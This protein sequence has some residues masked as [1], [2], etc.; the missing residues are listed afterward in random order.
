MWL[1]IEFH[2]ILMFVLCCY[3][4]PKPYYA[5]A[6][7]QNAITCDLDILLT[8]HSDAIIIVAGDFN[9]L[10]TGF[11]ER[12]FGLQQM[13]TSITHGSKIIDKFCQSR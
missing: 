3:Q 1:Q 4:P 5:A 9:S 12:D 6:E 11:L 13:V 2:G 7:M 10:E 8:H